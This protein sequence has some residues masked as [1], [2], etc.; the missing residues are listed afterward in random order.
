MNS[1]SGLFSQS[2][3]E[4]NQ[5]EQASQQMEALRHPNQELEDEFIRQRQVH[6]QKSEFSAPPLPRELQPGPIRIQEIRSNTHL[7]PYHGR[8]VTRV[9]GVVT[10]I[11]PNG[12]FFQDDDVLFDGKSS[13]ALFVFG[14]G[15]AVS[16]GDKILVS[17]LV[18]EFRPKE[19]QREMRLSITNIIEP[20]IQVLS[21]N[22]PLP[23]PV[24]LGAS[25][26]KIPKKL[27]KEGFEGDIEDMDNVIEPETNAID[28]FESLAGMRVR[29]EGYS[30]TSAFEYQKFCVRENLHH[31]V[32]VT[33]AGGL[34]RQSGFMDA[35]RLMVSA[36]ILSAPDEGVDVGAKL[37]PLIGVLHYAHDFF[38][39]YYNL[40]LS[41]PYQ[42]Q[43]RGG[44]IR[45]P[46]SKIR[47]T[48]KRMTI[49]SM[50]LNNL[51]VNSK[52]MKRHQEFA[53]QIVDHLLLPDILVLHEVSDPEGS[54]KTLQLLIEQ[55][56]NK[57]GIR[58]ESRTIIPQNGAD[59]GKLGLN[60]HSAYLFNPKRVEFVDHSNSSVNR[61]AHINVDGTGRVRLTESPGRIAPDHEVFEQCRKPLVGE[62]QF[63]GQSVFVIG[64]HFTSKLGDD[65]LYGKMQPPRAKSQVKR[66]SQVEVTAGFIDEIQKI[67]PDARIIVA[68]DMNDFTDSDA[69]SVFRLHD[70]QNPIDKVP[71]KDRYTFNH[72]GLSQQLDHMFVSNSLRKNLQYEILHLN[73][74]YRK[75][76]TD[77]DP[78]KLGVWMAG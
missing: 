63:N 48:E 64:T 14:K 30:A 40:I 13:T 3:L 58:Y 10:A 53:N 21:Q 78:I 20:E 76:P 7:S 33:G 54:G 5:L 62:F 16:L 69:L 19:I 57:S 38:T 39:G 26:M 55:I 68:G 70:L 11:L 50:N 15:H 6:K 71:A 47:N 56:E 74:D 51:G 65:P 45:R 1:Y 61:A 23:A 46:V 41:E 49:A 29:L 12:F 72:L 37:G 18:Q 25:G 2:G 8:R 60:I 43:E 67:N 52:D 36:E 66:T 75:S 34:L 28:F 73:V 24:Q 4:M 9:P 59:G 22:Q 44:L 17:G 32:N 35:D 42:V 27:Y 31:D 77:H